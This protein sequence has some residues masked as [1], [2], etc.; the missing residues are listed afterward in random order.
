MVGRH[1]RSNIITNECLIAE[2]EVNSSRHSYSGQHFGEFDWT[3]TQQTIILTAFYFGYI[4]TQI[5]AGILVDRTGAKW[6]LGLSLLISGILSIIIPITV[7]TNNSSIVPIVVL[8]MA[9]GL[10]QGS[11]LPA[12]NALIAKWMP[13][14]ERS[15]AV[16]LTF[17]GSALG[18]VTTLPLTG[19][20][21]SSSFMGGWPAIY[22]MLGIFTS[23]WFIFWSLFIFESP[24]T[25]P[26][27]SQKEYNYIKTG[28]SY[29]T[30]KQIPWKSILKS[31]R[32]YAVM[33]THFGYNWGYFT[34]LTLLPT[35]FANIL[36]MNV[37]TNG[38]IS[39]LPYITNVIVSTLCS[40]ITDKLRQKNDWV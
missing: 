8:R 4:L 40:Y 33:L 36:H 18:V 31:Y 19:Y 14:T 7:T 34:L 3:D 28:Q 27:I 6:I 17:V 13:K 23:I 10:V 12:Y 25:H 16:S 24:D 26:Y 30:K 2:E 21:C 15:R 1:N 38:F 20:L 35:Y 22:Y 39:S 32:V 5:P 11:I 37:K 9:Q 29:E